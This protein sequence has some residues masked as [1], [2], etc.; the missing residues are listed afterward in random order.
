[1]D[2]ESFS[3]LDY[4][5]QFYAPTSAASNRAELSAKRLMELN[6]YVPVRALAQPTSAID[7]ALLQQ[8]QCVVLANASEAE[9]RR[10]NALCHE[11][12]I[13]FVMA[14]SRGAFARVFV[15]LGDAFEVFDKNGEEPM[16]VMLG[17]I[18]KANPGVV[19]TV[20]SKRHG[21]ETGDWVKFSEVQGM[22]EL[23]DK[24]LQITGTL[25]Y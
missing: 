15:D 4:S 21:L 20:N 25:F 14:E 13:G 18:T 8:F 6:P 10:I 3:W 23:N 12:R 5:T 1:M 9:I 24:T 17:S 19:T 7:A 2:D 16:E 22:V 11:R